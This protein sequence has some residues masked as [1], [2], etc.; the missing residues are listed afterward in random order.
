LHNSLIKS[1]IHTIKNAKVLE[2][3][4]DYTEL[5]RKKDVKNTKIKQIVNDGILK[6][7]Y[8]S[9]ISIFLNKNSRTFQNS[10]IKSIIRITKH[11]QNFK[12]FLTSL[13]W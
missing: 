6:M 11:H 12:N 5:N 7:F 13:D 9:N 1:R 10:L 2:F 4:D 8:I 3:F